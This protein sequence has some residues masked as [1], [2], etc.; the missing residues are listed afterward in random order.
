MR[1]YR[2]LNVW[3]EGIRLAEEVYKL[4]GLLPGTE[5]D[6]LKSQVCKSSISIP[7][8]IAEGCSS[9]REV[10][11][12]RFLEIALVSSF[13]LETQFLIVKELDLIPKNKL[14]KVLDLLDKEQKM[15]NIF[16]EKL[17]TND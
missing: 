3:K 10:D 8:N 9:K 4:S 14:N 7:S 16:V 1:N 5:K 12:K 11:F 6:G 2:D 15:L 13:E 17:E